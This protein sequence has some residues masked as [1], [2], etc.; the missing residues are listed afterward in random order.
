M[1]EGAI[2]SDQEQPV[3]ESESIVKSAMELALERAARLESEPLEIE[4]ETGTLAMTFEELTKKAQ[5]ADEYLTQLQYKQ[6]EFDNYRKRTLKERDE[7]LG[8]TVPVQELL[9]VID[10]LDL[11]LASTG[12]V[13]AI[14]Q[15]VALI[16]NQLWTLLEKKGVERIPT[17]G[18]PFDPIHHEAIASQPNDSIPEGVVAM[19][20]QSGFKVGERILRPS[21]VVVS[22]GNVSPG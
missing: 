15:G 20:Y 4:T 3:N 2:Q 1:N 19:E 11:A 16:R 14:R 18:E 9:E 6:A 17:E 7:L 10:H 5:L 13:E 12:D 21:K 22:S 8:E